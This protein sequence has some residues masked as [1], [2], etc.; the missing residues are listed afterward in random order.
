MGRCAVFEDIIFCPIISPDASVNVVQSWYKDLEQIGYGSIVISD[1]L[2]LMRDPYILMAMAAM[3]TF[4][5][6]IMLTA[7]NR[8][9]CDITATAGALLWHSTI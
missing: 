6:Q 1:T 9:T 2:F 7:T 3:N 4:C 8:L 5:P